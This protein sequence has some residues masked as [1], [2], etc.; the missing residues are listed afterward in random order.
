MTLGIAANEKLLEG[1][2]DDFSFMD[3]VVDDQT[4]FHDWATIVG[5]NMGY[6]TPHY[7]ENAQRHATEKKI[8]LRGLPVFPRWALMRKILLIGGLVDLTKI[9]NLHKSGADE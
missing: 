4:Q 8:V 2:G 5:E 9:L 7:K 3:A 6:S 1:N